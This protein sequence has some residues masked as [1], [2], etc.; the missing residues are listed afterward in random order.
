MRYLISSLLILLHINLANALT[1]E[2]SRS[3][4]VDKAKSDLKIL[5]STDIDVFH[6]VLSAFS[7]LNPTISVNYSTASTADIYRAVRQSDSQFDLI[8]SSAM[9]LQMKLV[10]DGFAKS[11]SI[12]E[13]LD[14]PDWS[15]WQNKLYGF[16]LEPIGMVVSASHFNQGELPNTRRKL[17]AFL[18]ANQE[19]FQ[20]KIITYDVTTSG[21]GFLLATQDDRQSNSFWRLAEVMGS[22]ES[23]L[24]C[25]SGQMLDAVNNEEYLLAYNIIGSYA[26]KRSKRQKNLRVVYFQDYTHMLLRTAFVPKN[27]YNA[28]TASNFLSFLRSKVGQ[29]FI[30]E[31]TGMLSL[32]SNLLNE[33]PYYKPIRLDTGLLVYLDRLKRQRFLD[34]WSAA[35]IQ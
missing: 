2:A 34:E 4:G 7:A 13:N 19:T 27:S 17:I 31:E 20:E 6:P 22:L 11:I 8:M 24:S 9:D 5:S 3:Y 16:S 12:L 23:H 28:A 32:R 30:E 25:C 26:E 14:I 35:L 29:N 10:N 21:A 1:I 18:R 33:N 15:Q